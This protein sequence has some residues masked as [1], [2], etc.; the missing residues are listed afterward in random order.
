MVVVVSVFV[1][2]SDVVVVGVTIVVE[3][4]VGVTTAVPVAASGAVVVL[5]SDAG[6]AVSLALAGAALSVF[7]GPS[8]FPQATS[9]ATRRRGRRT[10]CIIGTP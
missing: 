3:V 1:A 7:G 2:T 10:L 4:S 9:A 6:A 5:V 8:F